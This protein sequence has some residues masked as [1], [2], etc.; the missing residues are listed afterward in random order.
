[1]SG[2]SIK[3]RLIMMKWTFVPPVWIAISSKSPQMSYSLSLLRLFP[4]P[5]TVTMWSTFENFLHNSLV[6]TAT[7]F[8]NAGDL[9]LAAQYF[10]QLMAYTSAMQNLLLS[11]RL[12]NC[13]SLPNS[14]GLMHT[15]YAY[16][17]RGFSTKLWQLVK[18]IIKT[19]T[20]A[21][22]IKCQTQ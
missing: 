3:M 13:F 18:S 2:N 10:L 8:H 20:A 11:I 22:W 7:R 12:C 16:R 4:V 19:Q 6:L 15:S 1:M 9:V 21:I 17:Y 14:R 5:P